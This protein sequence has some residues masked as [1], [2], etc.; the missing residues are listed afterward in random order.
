MVDETIDLIITTPPYEAA[1]EP[2]PLTT[3]QL[4]T[5]ADLVID[6]LVASEADL[7][8]HACALTVERDSF[9]AALHA[10]V[11]AVAEITRERDR[12]R[13]RYHQ[14]L[15]EYRALRGGRAA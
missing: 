3:P 11:E 12:L 15:D 2:R 10:A 6:D 8:D 5:V 9:R 13:A 1:T 14:L 7:M 4:F